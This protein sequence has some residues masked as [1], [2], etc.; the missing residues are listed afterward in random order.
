LRIADVAVSE[1]SAGARL[2][3]TAVWDGRPPDPVHFVY[4]GVDAAAIVAPGDALAAALVVPCMTVGEDLV[5]DVPV[6]SKLQEGIRTIVDVF[7]SWKMG[8]YRTRL[9][10]PP[11]DR[12]RAPGEVAACFSG[13]ADSFFTILRERDD[14]I[15]TLLT[16]VGYDMRGQ[17]RPVFES[18]L[19]RL[20]SAASRMGRQMLVVDTNVY[21]VGRKHLGSAHHHGAV[22]AAAAHGLAGRLRRLHIP[23]SWSYRLMKPHGSHPFTDPLWSSES[24]EIVHDSPEF[25][26]IERV[27]AIAHS[28]VV[29]DTL[30][31]CARY[32]QQYNCGRCNKCVLVALALH[33]AGTLDRCRTLPRPTPGQIRRMLIS[34]L[35]HAR[36]EMMH[37]QLDDAELRDAV[38]FALRVS[39]LL[40]PAQPV[41]KALRRVGL[42]H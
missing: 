14:P 37:D 27:T 15:T 4:R 31:V 36:F 12:P 39:R 24:L 41:S 16:I 28:D 25:C 17:N 30:R 6:S 33:Q 18:F 21:E 10:A 20:S 19:P 23:S 34:P 40:R 5:L 29:L 38:A 8:T 42:R 3:A 32:P 22:L 7:L 1:T 26:K 9:E 35:W 2:A 13:G 11:V